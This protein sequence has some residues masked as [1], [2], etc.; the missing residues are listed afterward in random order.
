MQSTLVNVGNLPINNAALAWEVIEGAELVDTVGITS[1]SLISVAN[2]AVV[3]ANPASVPVTNPS[4]VVVTGNP[5]VAFANF[6]P[7]SVKQSIKLNINVKVKDDWWKHENKTE[8]KIKLSIKNKLD[9]HPPHGH[10]DQSQIITIVRQ[11]ARWVTLTGF[12]HNFGNN[13]MLVGGHI[14]IVNNC[15]GLPVNWPPGSNIQVIGLLQPN[16]TF[17]A[18]N[19]MVINVNIITGNFNSG[20]PLPGGN[21]GGGGSYGGGGGG[22]GGGSK[23]GG[24]KGHGGGSHGG[25]KGGGSRGR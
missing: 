22:G 12:P 15:T 10:H 7:I 11:N 19:I 13:R 18:I 16:G 2:N 1:A 4:A 3:A 17:L 9:I 8:I 5:V 20:V 25:S 23:G 24:S 14:V 6:Q 21:G